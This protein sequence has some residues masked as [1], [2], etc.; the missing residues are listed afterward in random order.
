MKMDKFRC[1]KCGA[2]LVWCPIECDFVCPVC[3][4]AAMDCQECIFE[5]DE[6]YEEPLDD[7]EWLMRDLESS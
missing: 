5:N 6:E 7:Y 1:K 2:Q 4:C 3:H